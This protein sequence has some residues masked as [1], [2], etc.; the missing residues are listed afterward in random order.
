MLLSKFSPSPAF[1]HPLKIC[2]GFSQGTIPSPTEVQQVQALFEQGTF[3]A[4]GR[5]LAGLTQAILA[6]DVVVTAWNGAKLIGMARALS[7]R[8]YRAT[9]WDVVVLP[10]YRGQGLG[11]QLVQTLLETPELKRVERIYLMTTHH[12]AFYERF[13]FQTNSTTTMVLIQ[14]TKLSH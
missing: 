2:L 12:Q 4:Q 8:V 5:D 6:S 14:S 9:V 1:S 10:Q 7:D 3:W 13:G 11:K